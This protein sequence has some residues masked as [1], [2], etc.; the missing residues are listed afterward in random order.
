MARQLQLSGESAPWIVMLPQLLEVPVCTDKQT[1]ITQIICDTEETPKRK[2][3]CV[4]K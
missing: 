3:Y 1:K 4:K 2:A